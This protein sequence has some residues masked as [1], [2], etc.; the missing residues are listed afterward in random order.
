MTTLQKSTIMKDLLIFT[1]LCFAF[2]L[3]AQKSSNVKLEMTPYDFSKSEMDYFK[4]F[5][6][7]S[8]GGKLLASLNGKW[9][10]F[11]TY[12]ASEAKIYAQGG[13]SV[14]LPKSLLN[15]LQSDPK[16]VA[17]IYNGKCSVYHENKGLVQTVN[18]V[19]VLLGNQ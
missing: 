18:N 1:L 15:K 10:V 4:G 6:E 3:Q 5:I 11:D 12:G 16:L 14:E 7:P 9:Y 2:S 8:G 13:S 19:R 17:F